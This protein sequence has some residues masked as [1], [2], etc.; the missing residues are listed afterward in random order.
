[1]TSQENTSRLEEN[2]EPGEDPSESENKPDGEVTLLP[3]APKDMTGDRPDE[4]GDS[5]PSED[6]DDT[7]SKEASGSESN[8]ESNSSGSGSGSGS[9]DSSQDSSSSK[10]SDHESDVQSD[11]K[12]DVPK[13]KVRR[14]KKPHQS[15]DAESDGESNPRDAKTSGDSAEKVK[16]KG[17]PHDSGIGDGTTATPMTGLS[18]DG[19]VALLGIRQ[20]AGVR[21]G[22]SLLLLTTLPSMATLEVLTDDLEKLSEKMFMSLEETN[23]VV[24]DKVL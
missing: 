10:S 22:D 6:D 13:C 19:V 4:Q 21:G 17:S 24:Y 5:K 12:G 20:V 8:S 3:P 18:G 2:V 15:S 9:E 23:I 14:K 11:T 7:K 16:A 1:M